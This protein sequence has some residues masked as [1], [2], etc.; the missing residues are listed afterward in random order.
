VTGYV[1]GP[2]FTTGAGPGRAVEGAGAAFAIMDGARKR[3]LMTRPGP[4]LIAAATAVVLAACA[5]LPAERLEGAHQA[6]A[7]LTT[8][9]A[10][11][12]SPAGYQRV[13]EYRAALDAELATQARRPGFLRSYGHAS[14][15]ADSLRIFADAVQV[16]VAERQAAMRSEVMALLSDG[17]QLASDLET[18]LAAVRRTG[19][20]AAELDSLRV[21]VDGAV[22]ALAEARALGEERRWGEAREIAAAAVHELYEARAALAGIGRG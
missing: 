2:A 16:M 17:A 19:A 9:G 10:G 14:E 12:Y 11:L 18:N 20:N 7:R 22:A 15:L 4:F 5:E 1:K 6:E 21:A 8:A 13:L 3:T